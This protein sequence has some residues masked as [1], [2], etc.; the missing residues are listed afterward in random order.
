VARLITFGGLSV[1]NGT[2]VNGLANP[3]SR[4]AILA[5]IAAAGERGIRREKLAALFWPD[6]DEDRARTALRQ[7]LFKLRRDIGADDITL[8]VVDLRLNADVLTSDVAEFE[9]AVRSGKFEEAA[10][11]YGGPFLDGVYVADSPEFERWAEER[12]VQYA[13][14]Y[15]RALEQ[16]ALNA[17]ARGDTRTAVGW[18]RKRVALDP[19]SG[20]VALSYMEALVASGD[21]EEAIRHAATHGEIVRREL[22]TEPDPRVVQY[23]N[24]LRETTPTIPDEPRRS[25]S[26]VP[27]AHTPGLTTFPEAGDAI[28]EGRGNAQPV[29]AS[30]VS[31]LQRSRNPRRLTRRVIYAGA[32]IITV[33]GLLYTFVPSGAEP[34]P[35]PR[36]VAVTAFHAETG[37]ATDSI[38]GDL[39]RS[40]VTNGVTQAGV[41]DV[42]A[43]D[44]VDSIESAR[45][46][47][48]ARWRALGRQ[49]RFVVS[50]RYVVSGESLHVRTELREASQGSVFRSLAASSLASDPGTAARAVRQSVLAAIAIR[51][52][53]RFSDWA[54]TI[55]APSSFAAYD[56]FVEGLRLAAPA[57]ESRSVGFYRAAEA[58]DSGFFLPSLWLLFVSGLPQPLRD[59]TLV[60]LESRR[61]ALTD[62]EQALLDYIVMFPT[63]DPRRRFFAASRLT[64]LAPG[65]DWFQWIY[66]GEASSVH[67][68][69]DALAALKRID[70]SGPWMSNITPAAYWMFRRRFHHAL[71]E[72][73]LA[74]DAVRRAKESRPDLGILQNAELAQLAALGRG[75]EV[76]AMLRSI[77]EWSRSP[78][79]GN[80]DVQ[81]FVMAVEE[82]AAHGYVAQARAAAARFDSVLAFAPDSVQ[83][84]RRTMQLR[85]RIL[86]ALR[87]PQ[88]ALE[89]LRVVEGEPTWESL[90]L[91]SLASA[92][93]GKREDADRAAAAL[94][95]KSQD[96]LRPLA[97]ARLAQVYALMGDRR[98]ATNALRD[99]LLG[100]ADL[101]FIWHDVPAADSLRRYP[102]AEAII[103]EAT[104][105]GQKK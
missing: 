84:R 19:Q 92:A 54:E 62:L 70:T 95:A 5:V 20:R 28:N 40:E 64:D 44:V 53:P 31:A 38:I 30:H 50:G 96:R 18:W 97:S 26:I 73:Q 80:T 77:E 79:D 7:A 2:L 39:I 1:R 88:R 32:A 102:P 45:R 41:A 43:P 22:E 14:D 90:A 85:A 3:R 105:Q 75:D 68:P 35:G 74:L 55:T 47:P 81:P 66:A 10:G 56:R 100:R 93:V 69:D 36:T 4:L 98:R 60:R 37:D 8:G 76:N 89:L 25:V 12:R 46:S 34:L 24:R 13:A 6:S 63:A 42:T 103:R 49:A 16:A 65:S 57:T 33:A 72:H 61:G 59:S 17:T 9:T 78:V 23:A 99:A 51:L 15:G 52:D 21:R 67:R 82:F 86:I 48:N 87:E 101:I 58:I 71:G 11:L 104:H 91:T 29:D 83:R 27:A 94:I